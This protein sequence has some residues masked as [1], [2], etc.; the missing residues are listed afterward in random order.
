[1][2]DMGKTGQDPQTYI[3]ALGAV[4]WELCGVTVNIYIF[5][6]QSGTISL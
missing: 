4:G 3:N 1:M 2:V 6:R 5:K